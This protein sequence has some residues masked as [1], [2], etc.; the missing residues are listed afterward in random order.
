VLV[1]LVRR[2]AGPTRR[3]A[4]RLLWWVAQRSASRRWAIMR[5]EVRKA[6]AW[7]EMAN[8]QVSR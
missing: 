4:A 2:N 3:L 7:F 1:P 8:S 5:S 6:D